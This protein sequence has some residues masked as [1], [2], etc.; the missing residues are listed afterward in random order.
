[1]NFKM[2]RVAKSYIAVIIAMV[3]FAFSYVWFKVAN[4]AYR[5]LT[6]VFARLLLAI[7]I[8]SFYLL[9]SRRLIKIKKEDWKYFLLIATFEPFLYFIFESKGLSLVSSTVAS[10]VISTIPVFTAIGAF[11]IFKEKLTKINYTGILISFLGILVFV[12]AGKSNL[13]FDP[14]GIL[15]MVMA[16]FCATGYS[17][18][19]RKLTEKYSPVNI[20]NAQNII[21]LILFLPVFLISE[22]S[23][24]NE[25]TFNAEAF[26][27]ILKLAVFASCGSFILFGYSV[28]TIGVTRANLFTNII[29]ILT[30]VIAFFVIGEVITLEK[31]F[32]IIIMISGLYLAQIRGNKILMPEI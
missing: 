13:S 30:A 7:I 23:H 25:I 31:Y 24:L 26:M 5:P 29:P 18:T 9:S 10:V 12:L 6:I 28:I 8:L 2:S 17:L 14:K 11:I 16:V 22:G 19:L 20:V 4:E 3:F 32:G 21:G 15:L 1:M 27:A